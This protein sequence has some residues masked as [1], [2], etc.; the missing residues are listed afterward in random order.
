MNK[1]SNATASQPIADKKKQ[2][3]ITIVICL[4]LVVLCVIIYAQVLGF[5]LI[6]Y[7]DP[8]YLADNPNVQELSLKTITWAFTSNYAQN[9][10]PLTWISHMIDC[11][12]FGSNSMGHHLTSILLHIANTLLLF[13]ILKKMTGSILRSAFVAAL[14]AVHPLHVESVAW[15][16]E[17]KDVLCTFFWLLTMLAYFYYAN[18][19]NVRRYSLVFIALALALLSKPMAVTLPLI[20]ILLDY[21]PLRRL[22]RTNIGKLV[23]EKIP[24]FILVIGSCAATF[25]AQKQGGAVWELPL[26]LRIENA[27]VTYIA[28]LLKTFWP[29]KMGMFYPFPENGIALWKVAGSA[30]LLLFITIISIRLRKKHPYL[31]TGW[32]WYVITL[33]PVIGIVQVGSKSMADRYTYI[34]LIGIFIAVA[35]ILPNVLQRGNKPSLVLRI[36]LGAVI[37]ALTISANIQAG[38]WKNTST[39]FKHTLEVTTDNYTIH[40]FY[41]ELLSLKGN[42]EAAIGQFRES[43]RITPDFAEGYYKIG[44]IRARQGRFD[45]AVMEFLRALEI[46]PDYADANFNLAL[47]LAR[48]EKVDESAEYLKAALEASKYFKEDSA[49]IVTGYYKRGD[50]DN[51]WNLIQVMKKAGVS[52]PP[53]IEAELSLLNTE[54][55]E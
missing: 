51:A 5:S 15:V 26:L 21:W 32:M 37:L 44:R 17:R 25:I 38:Y 50:F 49:A 41:G 36:F 27:I 35:W 47:A 22:N 7:D 34:P 1:T 29:M 3:R 45:D 6:R 8:L 52:P 33:V 55:D 9:W 14:F 42:D 28:Y 23:L 48:Q 4:L 31:I 54:D 10:H 11:R 24:L 30:L 53:D 16:S 19:P 18:R 39:L 2:R 43:I 12:V 13:F 40:S 46:A 20:L